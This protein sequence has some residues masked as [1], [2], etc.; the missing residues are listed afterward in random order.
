MPITRLSWQRG[1]LGGGQLNPKIFLTPRV[2]NHVMDGQP[3]IVREVDWNSGFFMLHV[4]LP[5]HHGSFEAP[6]L[7]R[8]RS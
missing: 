8:S 3:M 4:L 2:T 1:S 7:E 5:L 6:M